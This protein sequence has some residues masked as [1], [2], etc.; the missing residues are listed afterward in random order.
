MTIISP[1]GKKGRAEELFKA[2]FIKMIERCICMQLLKKDRVAKQLLCRLLC[3][4]SHRCLEL[5]DAS[6]DNMQHWAK[7]MISMSTWTIISK[8]L[9]KALFPFSGAVFQTYVNY[10]TSGNFSCILAVL[11]HIS[12][13]AN[14]FQLQIWPRCLTLFHLFIF[15]TH[16]HITP[17]LFLQS[18]FFLH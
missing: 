13:H 10:Q 1:E 15:A 5:F 3:E 8:I 9:L 12:N 17:F 6:H 14:L 2:H 18:F 11:K 7:S 16:D 4:T